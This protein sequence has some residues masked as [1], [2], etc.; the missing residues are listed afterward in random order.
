MTMIG[1]HAI[2]C[3]IRQTTI[4]RIRPKDDA[5]LARS[6]AQKYQALDVENVADEKPSLSENY[7]G[8]RSAYFVMERETGIVGGAG[9][10]PATQS[11]F[12]AIR[13]SK[14]FCDSLVFG[15][16]GCLCWK[17]PLSAAMLFTILNWVYGEAVEKY[18]VADPCVL[19]VAQP[20]EV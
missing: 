16:L 5:A 18:R 19:K 6:L 9:I 1:N 10:A 3:Q 11:P 8:E 7:L 4:R 12:P 17:R 15:S 2:E 13:I 14:R 20:V